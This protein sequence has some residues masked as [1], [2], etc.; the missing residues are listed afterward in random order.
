[1]TAKEYFE[2]GLEAGNNGNHKAAIEY[3]SKAIEL[4]PKY[5]EAYFNRGNAKFKLSNYTGAIEDFS[6][7]KSTLMTQI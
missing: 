7:P 4:E 6:C 2:K 1:M 3:F 5:A